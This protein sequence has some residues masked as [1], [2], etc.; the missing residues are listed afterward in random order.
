GRPAASDPGTARACPGRP[1]HSVAATACR[2]AYQQAQVAAAASTCSIPS[3]T[4]WSWRV[5]LSPPLPLGRVDLTPLVLVR[6]I[7]G[8]DEPPGMLAVLRDGSGER[9]TVRPERVRRVEARVVGIQ[10]QTSSVGEAH[11]GTG[12]PA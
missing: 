3:A 8:T 11:P 7:A 10:T 2:G 6:Q 9:G 12:R 4:E 5:W 1:G